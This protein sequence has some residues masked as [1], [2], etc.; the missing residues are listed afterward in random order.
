VVKL[1]E[2][3]GELKT[4]HGK[5]AIGILIMQDIIAVLFLVAAAGQVPSI[6]A[7]SLLALFFAKPLINKLLDKSGHGEL[8]PLMGFFL[9]LGGYELFK[10][11]GIKGDLG[12]LMIGI[13]IANHAKANELAKSLLSFKDLFLIGFFLSIGFSALPTLNMLI[14]ALAIMLLVPAKFA[15]FYFVFNRFRLRG[16]TSYLAS[17]ALGNYSEFGLIVAAISVKAGWLENDWLVILALAVSFSFVITSII[18]RKAHHIYVNNKDYIKRFE[19]PQPL[20]EDVIHQPDNANILVIGMGRVGKGAYKSL[21]NM[22]DDKVWGMDADH[23]RIDKLSA[24]GLS[25]FCGDGEDIDMWE[26]LNLDKLKLVLIALPSIGDQLNI[27]EQLQRAN[28]QGKTAAIARYEDD[29]KKLLSHGIDKVFNFY[30]EA[31]TGFAEESL[32][33]IDKETIASRHELWQ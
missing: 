29:R 27:I 10:L 19:H 23:R 26:K 33:L 24:N 31:G 21:C 32:S 9:A 13:L 6:W 15:V 7:L 8:L 2:E 30:T 16:R 17:L 18:Y 4:R 28:Y 14:A 20:A 25:V 1:L 22:V 5:I 3:A 11:V 12:A